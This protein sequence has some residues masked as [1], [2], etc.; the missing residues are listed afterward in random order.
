MSI[1]TG[2]FARAHEDGHD[3]RSTKV[4]LYNPEVGKCLCGYVPHKTMQLCLCA[5]GMVYNYIE[6]PKCRKK[7]KKILKEMWYKV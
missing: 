7:G 1:I 2:Y 6:C 3:A 4:H 5:T